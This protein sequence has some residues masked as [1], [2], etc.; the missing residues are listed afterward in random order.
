MKAL[1]TIG[2]ILTFLVTYSQDAKKTG[3]YNDVQA[4]QEWCRQ[5]SEIIIGYKCW[6]SEGSAVLSMPFIAECYK[7]LAPAVEYIPDSIPLT[8][9][10]YYEFL[11]PFFAP[12]DSLTAIQIKVIP[13]FE[14]FNKWNE[15]QNRNRI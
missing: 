10:D 13:S 6:V 1:F 5:Q 8:K 15:K 11:N 12:I 14:G 9:C 7:E 4:Y 2:L 3:T